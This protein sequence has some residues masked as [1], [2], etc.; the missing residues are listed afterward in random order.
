MDRRNARPSRGR[1]GRAPAGTRALVRRA[2]EE[3]RARRDRTTRALL[4][5]RTPARAAVVAQ[6]EGVLSG[7]AAAAETARAV[8]LTVALRAR[9]GDRIRAGQTV[10]RLAGDARSILA[11]ERT[12]LNLLMHL[13]GVATATARAVR[14]ASGRRGALAVYATR[15]TLPGLRDLEKA[16]VVHGGG[17]PHRRDLSDGILLKNNHLALVPLREAVGRV[18]RRVGARVPV[19]VEV[20]TARDAVRAV[21]AGADALLIDNRTPAGVRRIVRE[22][23][24]EGLRRGTWVEVSGGITPDS[25]ARYRGTGADAASLGSLTHSARAVPFHLVLVPAGRARRRPRPR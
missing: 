7:L 25:I 18:R 24:A 3:D 16:A 1:G 11:V 6:S 10:L 20:Q 9:D 5:R 13:T 12:L 17:S 19:Q 2:L 15:K 4:G 23:E 8:H 14:S 21:R 22:L